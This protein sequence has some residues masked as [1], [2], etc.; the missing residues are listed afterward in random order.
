MKIVS[1][2]I[3]YSVFLHALKVSIILLQIVPIIFCSSWIL[4]RCVQVQCKWCKMQLCMYISLANYKYEI[5]RN[6]EFQ[7]YCINIYITIYDMLPQ[8]SLVDRKNLGFIFWILT[9]SSSSFKL[10]N[11]SILEYLLHFS[12][13]NYNEDVQVYSDMIL[14]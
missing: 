7:F 9:S 1:Y 14:F 11:I 6:K 8:I 4:S 3:S 13:K 2:I 10:W 5:T 12:Q